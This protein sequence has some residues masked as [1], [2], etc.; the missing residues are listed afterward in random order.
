MCKLLVEFMWTTTHHKIQNSK[1]GDK[2][3]KM[4][5]HPLP[6]PTPLWPGKAPL[7][8]FPIF[9]FSSLPFI[10]HLPQALESTIPNGISSSQLKLE[11]FSTILSPHNLESSNL[12]PQELS[13]DLFLLSFGFS[14]WV[15]LI[16]EHKGRI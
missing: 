11:D 3:R 4:L 7:V 5:N 6:F 13:L 12:P 9:I 1:M 16:Q 2:P 8:P 14:L 15:F 10:S